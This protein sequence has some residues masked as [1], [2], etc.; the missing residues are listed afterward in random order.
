[1]FFLQCFIWGLFLIVIIIGAYLRHHNH[2]LI[3]DITSFLLMAM[4]LMMRFGLVGATFGAIMGMI[5]AS[6]KIIGIME[7]PPLVNLTG[8]N[9]PNQ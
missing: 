9:I 8:G 4:Q 3:G 2:I 1:M 5:G 7:T 6:V